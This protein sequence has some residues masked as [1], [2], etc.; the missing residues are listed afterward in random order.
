MWLDIKGQ[1]D[2]I[3][4]ALADDESKEWFDAKVKFMIDDNKDDFI[5]SIEKIRSRFPQKWRNVDLERALSD[6]QDIII[7][8]CGCDGKNIKRNLEMA[9]YTIKCWCDSDI[10]LHNQVVD[11]KKVISPEELGE[12]HSSS[13]V[14]IGSSKYETGI[15]TRLWD[16]NF[17]TKNIFKF[18][19][20]Q[21]INTCGQQ[22]FDVFAPLKREVLVDAGAY[23]GDTI[24]EFINWKG[25][26][27]YKIYA[28]ELSKGMCEVIKNRAIPNVEVFNASAWNKNE[29]LS[30]LDN[31]RGSAISNIG[32]ETVL[33]RTIDSIVEGNRVT[34]IKMDIE[35]AEFNALI[36][37]ENTIRKYKP[38]L[39]VSIYHKKDDILKLGGV[40]LGLNPDYKLYIRHYTSCTWETV[41]YAV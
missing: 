12:K 9:G 26:D 31:L 15:R 24:Q 34:Y 10:K 28:I 35:G 20:G 27:D 18:L 19:W 33:G 22:Y 5:T 37:A 38:R 36:G 4:C 41:L 29:D 8:G 25:N 13:L 32:R 17:P 7:Y 3:Y 16:V 1:L 6:G 21:A 30:F 14:I 23:N 11:G 2:S 40:I 39:A